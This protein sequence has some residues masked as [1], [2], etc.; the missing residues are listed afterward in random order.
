M[1]DLTFQPLFWQCVL[2]SW[3]SWKKI[4]VVEKQA[5]DVTGQTLTEQVAMGCG[6]LHCVKH[7]W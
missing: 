6:A 1:S 5:V 7:G 3:S 4:G 2:V